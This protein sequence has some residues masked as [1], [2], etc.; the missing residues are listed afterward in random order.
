M[1]D[2]TYKLTFAMSDGSSQD[3]Q[4]TAPQGPKGDIG[5]TGPQGPKGDTGATGPQGPQG[6]KGDIDDFIYVGDTEPSS[7]PI[8]WFSTD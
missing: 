8:L 1:A 5:E 7:G 3:V 6:P 2:K 4:F